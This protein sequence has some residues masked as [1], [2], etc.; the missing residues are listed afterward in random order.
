MTGK[1]DKTAQMSYLYSFSSRSGI[2]AMNT[3]Y[4]HVFRNP[5]FVSH[6]MNLIKNHPG[7]FPHN[8][9]TLNTRH[10]STQWGSV[11]IAKKT[12]FQRTV[13]VPK[14]NKLG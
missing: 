2:E 9:Q 5:T 6:V 14:S 7:H 10:I 8:L 13:N 3:Q 1:H 4:N 12:V 11:I